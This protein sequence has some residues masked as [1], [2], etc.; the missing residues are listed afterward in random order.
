[1]AI[2]I[3]AKLASFERDMGKMAH[4]TQRSADRMEGRLPLLLFP[5]PVPYMR[6]LAGPF[7]TVLRHVHSPRQPRTNVPKTI[8]INAIMTAAGIA[9]NVNL[10]I[11]SII[12]QKLILKSVTVTR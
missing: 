3:S 1:M 8:H 5:D 6:V 4:L 11:N 9:A 10:I 7:G 12:D 2:D